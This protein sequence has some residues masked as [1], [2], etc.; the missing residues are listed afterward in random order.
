MAPSKTLHNREGLHY[1]R[2]SG[3][4]ASKRQTE[5]FYEHF[6]P[7]NPR[8]SLGTDEVGLK[9]AVTQPP[10]GG[11]ATAAVAVLLA[12]ALGVRKSAVTLVS[13]QTSRQKVFRVEGVTAEAVNRLAPGGPA[14]QNRKR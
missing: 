8:K 11:R 13:G 1:M 10:E 7:E 6:I 4:T 14:P 12:R 3:P 2:F 9:I 5:A